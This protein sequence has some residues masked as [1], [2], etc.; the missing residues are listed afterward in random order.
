MFMMSQGMKEYKI[1]NFADLMQALMENPEWLEEQRKMIL[2]QEILEFPR[3]FENFRHRMEER[4]DTLEKEVQEVKKKADAIERKL[5]KD[6]W[7]L[8]GMW[9]EMKV[10]DNI[11]S[12]F[13]EYLLDARAID[14]EKINKDLFLAMEKGTISKEERI[15]VLRLDLII[16]GTLL[17]TGEPVLVAV[18]VSYT[19]DDFDVQRAI[20]RA[21]ILE[22]AMDKRVLP[23]VVGYKITKKAQN[24]I[25]K[26]GV[27]KI[28][29]SE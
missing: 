21:K 22:K 14:Q 25:E 2:T 5:D 20:N 11:L 19:I 17:N 8:K 23:A 16:E 12:F 6:V 4:F 27:L 9:L 18:E 10:K 28:V 3:K 7:P 13:S 15:D 24:L 26:E 1:S 29:F